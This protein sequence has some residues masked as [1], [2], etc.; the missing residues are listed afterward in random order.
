[1]EAVAEDRHV[2][3]DRGELILAAGVDRFGEFAVGDRCDQGPGA[4]GLAGDPAEH[5]RRDQ[6][7]EDHRRDGQRD[8]ALD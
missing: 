1:V 3:E 7:A 5:C 6:G 2:G 4:A 8:A